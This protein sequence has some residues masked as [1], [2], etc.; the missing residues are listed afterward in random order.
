MGRDDDMGLVV[1]IGGS[2]TR[3]QLGKEVIGHKVPRN[4]EGAVLEAA[5]KGG[6]VILG[7]I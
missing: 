4:E 6:F 7:M 5:E 2:Q 1:G 3:I